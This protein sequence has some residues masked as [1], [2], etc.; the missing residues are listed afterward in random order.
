MARSNGR[1]PGKGKR[2]F[3][4]SKDK[5]ARHTTPS[6]FTPKGSDLPPHGA[7]EVIFRSC[8]DAT[9]QT[10]ELLHSRTDSTDRCPHKCLHKEMA[11]PV[12]GA[13]KN[14]QDR[15]GPVAVGKKQSYNMNSND[16]RRAL[17]RTDPRLTLPRYPPPSPM[18]NAGETSLSGPRR[19]ER[20]KS[21]ESSSLSPSCEQ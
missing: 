13:P 19:G 1:C 2:S 17:A 3:L 9:S 11:A 16:R 5:T 6:C 15:H 8:I 7:A 10:E 12:G 4:V 18:Y 20:R 14:T 21:R